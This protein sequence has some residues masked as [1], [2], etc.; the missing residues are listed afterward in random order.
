[1]SADTMSSGRAGGPLSSVRE[2]TRHASDVLLNLDQLRHRRAL[3]DVTLLVGGRPLLAHKA[4]LAACS[5]FFYSIFLAQGG[6]EVSVLT[7]PGSIQPGGFQALLDFMYTSRLPLTPASVP[8]LLSAATYLQMEHVVDACHRFIQASYDRASF[9][10]KPLPSPVDPKPLD[11]LRGPPDASGMVPAGA[12]HPEG[13]ARAPAKDSGGA[14]PGGERGPPDSPSRSE[15]HPASP[16]ESSGCAPDPKACNWKKYKFIVLNSLRGEGAA[17]PVVTV[18]PVHPAPS[19][20]AAPVRSRCRAVWLWGLQA[21]PGGGGGGGRWTAGGQAPAAAPHDNK[22]FKC[23]LCRSAFRYKGNLASHRAVHTGEKPYRC[24]VCGAQFNRP[25]NLKTHS[26]IHSG[27]KP[28][29]CETCG[30]S[31][32]QVAHLRAH[33]LIHTGEKPYPCET[34]GTRFRH[35]QTL[36]SHIRIHTGE[37]PYQ[38]E[39]CHLHFRHKSQLRLHLRQKHGAVTNTK[40]RYAVLAGPS[41]ARC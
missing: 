21:G 16:R 9:Y 30:S 27:E 13:P 20:G 15:G 40:I 39:T 17:P 22:P 12:P 7:L 24:G 36:K 28:Y 14:P 18:P 34:C 33:V 26:R 6:S 41:G 2:F 37:K 23:Q 32:V 10:P 38:C 3:T 31:F 8:A 35:L 25:A 4:V 11:P 5:G 19:P 29:K 1:M